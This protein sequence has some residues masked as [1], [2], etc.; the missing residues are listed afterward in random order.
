MA[1]MEK[2]IFRIRFKQY[3]PDVFRP[4][5]LLYGHR[6][7]FQKHLRNFLTIVAKGYAQRPK[8]LR[9]LDLHRVAEPDWFQKSDMIGYVCYVDRFAGTLQGVVGKIPYLKSLGITY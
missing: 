4:L 5:K 8:E 9:L 3:F 2:E 6:E 1:A 7:D